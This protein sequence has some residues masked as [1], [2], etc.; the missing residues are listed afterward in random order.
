MDYEA[1][2]PQVAAAIRRNLSNR[3]QGMAGLQTK[4]VN[5]NVADLYFP[6]QDQP[7]PQPALR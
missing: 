2:I 7:Q 4:E 6:G 1:S 3:L 5:I